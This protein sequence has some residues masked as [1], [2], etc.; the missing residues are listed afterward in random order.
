MKRYVWNQVDNITTTTTIDYVVSNTNLLRKVNG[1]S[2]AIVAQ[3]IKYPDTNTTFT[4][5]TP[6]ATENNTYLL[7]LNAKLG[8][9]S[10]N[11]QF[12][13]YQRLP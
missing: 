4:K 6:S 7:K 13:I 1:S 8:T 11:Q 10:F 5:V 12:K 9:N 3:Y 2:G